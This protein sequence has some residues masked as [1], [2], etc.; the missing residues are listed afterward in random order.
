M[1]VICAVIQL[2]TLADG[3]GGTQT[4]GGTIVTIESWETLTLGDEGGTRWTAGIAWTEQG[5]VVVVARAV[6][7]CHTGTAWDKPG[8]ISIVPSRAQALG[9]DT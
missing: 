3:V 9:L 1:G 5:A 8:S 6:E 2:A 4:A 7:S